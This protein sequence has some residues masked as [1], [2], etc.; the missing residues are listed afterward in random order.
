MFG[1]GCGVW[2]MFRDG[3]RDTDALLVGV[4]LVGSGCH[5]RCQ[6]CCRGRCERRALGKSDSLNCAWHVRRL[7]HGPEPTGHRTRD[8]ELYFTAD[9][10][11]SSSQFRDRN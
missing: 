8:I 1:L 6:L 9:E 5:S 11:G 2:K 4:E 7:C 3:R 10:A